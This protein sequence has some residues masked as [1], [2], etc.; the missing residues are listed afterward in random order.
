MIRRLPWF[1]L[2]LSIAFNVFFAG[3]FI[4]AEYVTTKSETGDGANLLAKRLN[5]TDAQKQTYAQLRRDMMAKAQEMHESLAAARQE[6]WTQMGSGAAE[7]RKIRELVEFQADQTRRLHLL[8]ADHLRQF[9][10]ILTPDQSHTLFTAVLNRESAG[11]AGDR[12]PVR[13]EG[14]AAPAEQDRSAFRERLR[15]WWGE[16]QAARQR[17]VDRFDTD[18]DGKLSDEERA[19]VVKALEALKANGHS[20]R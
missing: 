6:F 8:M 17:L 19:E 14:A 13:P 4:H 20:P 5:L 2:M 16:G 18:G 3:G 9:Q 11:Q 7:P 1:L 10:S 15:N 12:Q